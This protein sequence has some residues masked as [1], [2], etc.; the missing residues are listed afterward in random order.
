[1]AINPLT[2]PEEEK[3]YLYPGREWLDTEGK[4]IQAHGGGILYVPE[5]KTFYWYG[6][7]KDG[8]TYHLQKRSVARVYNLSSFS[9]KVNLRLIKSLAPHQQAFME[10]FS[11]LSK[12][13][14][15]IKTFAFKILDLF[16]VDSYLSA[17]FIYIPSR[18]KYLMQI[19][20]K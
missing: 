6:E 9:L 19:W 4:P 13:F 2:C 18:L 20:L 3:N 16:S 8:R 12:H 11:E 5:T 17:D 7:N 14:L 1:L 10:V 15:L